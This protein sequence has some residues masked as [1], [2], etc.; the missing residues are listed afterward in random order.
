MPP[1]AITAIKSVTSHLFAYFMVFV[2]LP[3]IVSCVN[4]PANL[5]VV[6]DSRCWRQICPGTSDYHEVLRSLENEP[7]IK[8]ETIF[9]S[10]VSGVRITQWNV[11]TS[12]LSSVRG[13][14]RYKDDTVS[15]V[16]LITRDSLDLSQVVGVLGEPDEL[17]ATADC[18][19]T[20]SLFATFWY[21]EQGIKVDVFRTHW[22][23]NN[24]WEITPRES[25]SAI[26]YYEPSVY[27]E[28]LLSWEPLFSKWDFK[29]V[30]NY[31]KPWPGF[32]SK[33]DVWDLCG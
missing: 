9:D 17:L 5:A 26:I 33:V 24:N 1:E 20:R 28:M 27:D 3:F 16:E 10:V 6:E 19:E 30:S 25:V 14:A 8:K 21:R 15:M 18:I 13:I 32:N 2:S 22:P 7:D 31:I 11:A 12:P 23:A 29:T 4:I